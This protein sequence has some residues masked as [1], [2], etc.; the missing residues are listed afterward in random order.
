MQA[1]MPSMPVQSER[2]RKLR[3]KPLRLIYVELAF[4]NGGMMRDLSEEG[5][6][7]RA[8]IPVKQGDKTS[9]SFALGEKAR[10]EGEGKVL[11][12]DEGGRVA[13]VQFGEISPEMRSQIDDW[14]IEEEKVTDPRNTAKEPSIAP[15]ATMEELREEIRSTP[16]RKETPPPVPEETPVDERPLEEEPADTSE[17]Q[18]QAI[19]PAAPEVKVAAK[20]AARVET[21]PKEGPTPAPEL[22]KPKPVP[23][24][25]PDGASAPRV[26]TVTEGF[27]WRQSKAPRPSAPVEETSAPDLPPLPL[28]NPVT[29]IRQG[30]KWQVQKEEVEAEEPAESKAP[31]PDIS[32]ILIQPHGLPPRGDAPLHPLPEKPGQRTQHGEGV[33][34]TLTGALLVMTTLTVIVSLLVYHREVGNAFIRTGEALG[35]ASSSVAIP[36]ATNNANN[37]NT[38]NPPRSNNRSET[39]P[40]RPVNPA[41]TPTNP[42]TGSSSGTP[43]LG[44]LASVPSAPV[45][46]LSS[47]EPSPD[48]GQAEYLQ[49]V[50]L[51]RGRSSRS[52]A[53]EA[54]RLL[55][56]AVEKGN[57]SAEVS[58]ADLYWH[59]QGVARNCDQARILFTAAARKGSS[60]AQKQLRE[61]QRE[62]CE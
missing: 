45:T 18:I 32:E 44:D 14:L 1:S 39:Q 16:V 36:P 4:G 51:L 42:S 28:P 40:E 5:F 60:E 56:I 3:K 7:V 22:P 30:R 8:M 12:I 24:N 15:A 27:F 57:P 13:G 50:Q 43:P 26:A 38:N 9:F 55:W 2:R 29:P 49:A 21:A 41:P 20:E 37:T 52:D 19:P 33:S 6:A 23:A 48:S 34:F 54:V 58:L 35:G 25:D 53:V 31:L 10:I 46:P 11:W 61:F 47:P 17:P 62:G 59:G